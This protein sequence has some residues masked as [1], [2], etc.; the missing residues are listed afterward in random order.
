MFSV[1][2][3]AEG[4]VQ[5]T[6][7]SQPE[8]MPISIY[9]VVYPIYS[10]SILIIRYY[11]VLNAILCNIALYLSAIYMLV[12]YFM[13]Q[14]ECTDDFTLVLI[15]IVSGYTL[16]VVCMW[17]WVG[18]LYLTCTSCKQHTRADPKVDVLPYYI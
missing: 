7:Q 3:F 11:F 17:V 16:S 13:P 2:S 10:V 4:I 1:I 18:F 14:Q 9:F 5:L 8:C 12:I 15:K 6:E